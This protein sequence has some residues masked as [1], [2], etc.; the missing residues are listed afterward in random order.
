MLSRP[1]RWVE[2][3]WWQRGERTRWGRTPGSRGRGW[4]VRPCQDLWLACAYRR[5]CRRSHS[6]LTFR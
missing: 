5:G 2:Q 1:R 3:Y 4:Q 6:A